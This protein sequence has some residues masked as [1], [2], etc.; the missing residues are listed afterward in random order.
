MELKV[1]DFT[2]FPIAGTTSNEVACYWVYSRPSL[3]HFLWCLV[4]RY[5]NVSNV[6]QSFWI[7]LTWSKYCR[8]ELFSLGQAPYPGIHP[9]ENLFTKLVEGYRMDKPEN[10]T[11][12][13]SVLAILTCNWTNVYLDL[14]HNVELLE[15]RSE[16]ET[17][18]QC[19][20]RKIWKPFAR[21]SS[22]G[23]TEIFY[24]FVWF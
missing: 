18:V 16:N 24:R 14:R 11:Q 21:W 15:C 2:L 13:V 23:W 5:P 17:F 20:G 22:W 7:D 10:A 3:Q 4:I 19:F 6:K 12:E 1:F 9:N 8:W